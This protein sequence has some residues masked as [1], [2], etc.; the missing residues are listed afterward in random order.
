MPCCSED[1]FQPKYF[2]NSYQSKFPENFCKRRGVS[3]KLN[4]GNVQNIHEKARKIMPDWIDG[5]QLHGN[6]VINGNSSVF[7]SW[8]LGHAQP[9]GFRFGGSFTQQI[10]SSYLVNFRN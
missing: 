3:N 8:V 1:P 2:F 6:R 5:V 7:A 4:P 9:S 10:S